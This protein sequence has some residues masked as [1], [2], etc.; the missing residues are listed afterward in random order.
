MRRRPTRTNRDATAMHREVVDVCQRVGGGNDPCTLASR[1]DLAGCLMDR[2][3]YDEAAA[4]YREIIEPRERVHCPEDADTLTLRTNLAACL[5][6]SRRYEEAAVMIRKSL[7]GAGARLRPRS[8]G[9]SRV[10]GQSCVLFVRWKA[11]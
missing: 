9:D 6:G 11:V 10:E 8:H 5:L 7:E 3:E 2:G 1:N 4:I